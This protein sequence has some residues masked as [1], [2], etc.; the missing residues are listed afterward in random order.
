V[1]RKT[2]KKLIAL[3]LVFNTIFFSGCWD[4]RELNELGLVMAVGVDKKK[5][6]DLY[7]VTVQV[8]KPSSAAGQGG[9]SGGGDQPVWVGSAQ[10]KTIFEAIRNIAKFSS[11]RIMWAHNNIIIIGESLAEED[12]TP[13]VDFFTMN[14]ELR[15]K[16]WVAIAH[17]EAKPYVEAK[18]G[19]ENI[20]AI[21]MAE[22]FRYHELPAESVSTDMVTLFRDFKSESKQPLV[23]ALNKQGEDEKAGDESQI[24]LEG[25]AV[26]KG[27]KLIGWTSPEETRG[28]AWLRNEMN[29]AVIVLTD[30]GQKKQKISVELDDTKV[31]INAEIGEELPIINIEVKARGDIAEIDAAADITIE[32]LKSMVKKEAEKEIKREINL[33][34]EKVQ[35]EF[36]SDVLG[37]GRVVHVADKKEWYKRID[38]KWE[39][40]YPQLSVNVN[41]TVEIDSATLYQEPI[42]YDD[43]KD[44]G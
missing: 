23:S 27:S 1:R 18:T 9:K 24:E 35:K 42:K 44:R 33:G 2:M 19:V 17:G 28:I 11:R 26:F 25:A 3:V 39:E 13:V 38:N 41:V 16:T 15:M 34:L 6:G 37:F 14:P 10:G 8:A 5:G 20:P 32:Q 43:K 22:L 21:S 36:K 12:I 30:V 40:M 7:T 29:K 4:S 31:K